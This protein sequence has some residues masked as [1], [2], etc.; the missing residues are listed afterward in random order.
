M[1][2]ATK[3]DKESIGKVIITV[4][5]FLIVG[6]LIVSDYHSGLDFISNFFNHMYVAKINFDF[7]PFHYTPIC[8]YGQGVNKNYQLVYRWDCIVTIQT[9][10]LV[11]V[12]L[13]FLTYGF[14][15][16]KGLAPTP[17]KIIEI[18]LVR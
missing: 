1:N 7:F 16:V 17:K 8:E 4:S 13:S 9:K 15:L 10:Y 3:K 12:F 5:F 6:S 11:F 14:L 18:I 2:E